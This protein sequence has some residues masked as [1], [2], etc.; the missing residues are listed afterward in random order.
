MLRTLSPGTLRQL[1]AGLEHHH[2]RVR[3]LLEQH[4]R[5]GGAD[6]PAADDGDGWRWT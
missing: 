6:G 3:D 1:R 5:I 2:P 4:P